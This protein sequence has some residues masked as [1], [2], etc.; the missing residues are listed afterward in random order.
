MILFPRVLF[1]QSCEMEEDTK[2]ED[3]FDE[4]SLTPGGAHTSD[5]LLSGA[6]LTPGDQACSEQPPG[7][8]D[9]THGT[10]KARRFPRKK[11]H[12]NNNDEVK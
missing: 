3:M 5:S 10:G 8:Q 6:R 1:S 4:L 9:T 7:S 12:W 2:G 11:Y